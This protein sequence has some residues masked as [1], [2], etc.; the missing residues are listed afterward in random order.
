MGF[1]HDIIGET[2]KCLKKM[3]LQHVINFIPRKITIS[4]IKR[5]ILPVHMMSGAVKDNK[6]PLESAYFTN[7]KEKCNIYDKNAQTWFF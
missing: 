1:Q 5:Y 4:H 7:C 6:K 2:H 3:N